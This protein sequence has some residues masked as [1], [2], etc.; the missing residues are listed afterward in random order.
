MKTRVNFQSLALLVLALLLAPDGPA[1]EEAHPRTSA[2]IGTA[3][4]TDLLIGGVGGVYFLAEP[5][6]LVVEVEKRDRNRRDVRTELRAILVGPDRRVHGEATIPDDG[7]P[8]DSGLGPAQRCRLAVRVDRKG[9]YALNIT[10]SQDRYG[11]ET[12]WGFRTNCPKYLIETARGHMDERHQEPIVLASPR[13]PG[14]VCF[15][16]RRE[17]FA[18]E[19]ADL[20]KDAGLPEVFDARGERVAPL[21]RD[22]NGT[23]AHTFEASIPRDAVPWQ[24]RLPAAQATINIDGVTRWEPDD[25]QPDIACWTPDPKSWF[26]LL[27]N[28]WLLTPYSRTVFGPPGE[29]QEVRFQIRNDAMRERTLQLAIEFPGAPWPARVSVERVRLAAKGTTTV[30]VFVPAPGTGESRVCHV[31]A[32]PLDDPEFSTYSTLTVTAGEAPATKPIAMPL[33]LKPYQHENEQFGHW[34]NYPAENEIY[35]DPQNRPFVR[36]SGGVA[37]SRDGQWHMPPTEVRFGPA[38][39]KVAFDRD[40]GV[41]ILA[42]SGQAA[43]LL[44]STDG[45]RTFTAS[46]IPGRED[47]P[48]SFDVEQ[49]TGQN[50]PEGPPPILRYT[51]TAKD[52]KLFWRALHDLELFLPKIINGVLV[53]GEPILISQQCIGLAAHSGIPASVV[54]RGR[55]VHV[56]WGE[57][58]DP[59]AKIAGLPAFVVTYDRATGKLG[60]PALVGYGAPANDIHNSPSITMDREGYLHVLGGTHGR[61][62]PYARSLQP[63]EAGAGWT[64]PVPASE[65]S[66]Q[67]YIG[68]MCGP[69]GTLHSVFRLWRSGIDP[70]PASSFGTLA[71]QRKR[72]G[73]PWEAPRVLIVPPFSEYSVYYHRM[74][75][76]RRGRLFLSY[77]YWS[78]FWFYRNDHAGRRRT[79]L[80]SPDG[81]ETWRLAGTKDLEP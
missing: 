33:V 15:L 24:L 37:T 2:G 79:L 48:R 40:N 16:P 70:F 32:T 75:I 55:K 35:F 43:S 52:E 46:V 19:I 54:S 58:T 22:A 36:T 5:G 31:R 64:E 66:N 20:P 61:P 4:I 72:P 49:F 59:K 11:Q 53:P 26:P 39:T 74:T 60:R 78:T 76:D 21:R 12:V 8:K 81:G 17:A 50:P 67:T 34:P 56:T 38:S 14:V 51:R 29:Q 28:R 77:D 9:V 41:Y 71:Y 3:S 13:R 62:F 80:M 68:L 65:N 63:N 1:V 44:H 73:W 25:L 6:E 7:R 69:D 23:A 10:V 45:G 57:A 30:S 27:E 42:R 47:R 18:M